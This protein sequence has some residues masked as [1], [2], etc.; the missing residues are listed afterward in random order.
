MTDVLE[1][2]VAPPF[3]M[4]PVPVIV[5]EMPPF[6]VMVAAAPKPKVK[7]F[8]APLCKTVREPAPRLLWPIIKVLF[9]DIVIEALP[10][11]VLTVACEASILKFIEPFPEF[12]L[13]RFA[14]PTEIRPAPLIVP[15]PLAV[16]VALPEEVIVFPIFSEPPVLFST[17]VPAENALGVVMS[18]AEVNENVEG[19][20]VMLPTCR[21][22][23]PVLLKVTDPEV[24][25]FTE[26]T[27]VV[28]FAAPVT[29]VRVSV[30]PLPMVPEPLIPFAP[31]VCK[32]TAVE[33]TT[34]ASS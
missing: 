28:K 30:P 22:A 29:C 32:L 1:T 10:P 8:P 20:L 33:A 23:A 15:A 11:V 24:E 25:E 12:K 21:D 7:S 14:P 19:A 26:V 17:S 5:A 2:K 27:F 3:V 31:E 18:P 9:V 16:S 13:N 6:A 34:L 4:L